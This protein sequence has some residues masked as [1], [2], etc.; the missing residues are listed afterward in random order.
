[1]IDLLQEQECGRVQVWSDFIQMSQKS[2][3]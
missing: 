2:T 1:L 3:D